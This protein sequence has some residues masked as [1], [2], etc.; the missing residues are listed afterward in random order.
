MTL[1]EVFLGMSQ[2]SG[3]MTPPEWQD[4]C[5]LPLPQMQADAQMYKDAIVAKSGPNAFTVFV[6]F[7]GTAAAV[8]GDAS[9]I[10]SAYTVFKALL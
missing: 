3:H 1:D 10:G 5:G 8:L 4:F 7:L 9:G 2:T 6:S